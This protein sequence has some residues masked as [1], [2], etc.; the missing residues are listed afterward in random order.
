MPSSCSQPH[1]TLLV[2]VAGHEQRGQPLAA[3]AMRHS[4]GPIATVAAG[5]RSAGLGRQRHKRAE[6]NGAR[7]C[8]NLRHLATAGCIPQLAQAVSLR[9]G[10]GMAGR[11]H[12]GG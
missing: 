2:D 8:C 6:I 11:V 4:W 7:V 1:L 12:S 5:W 9:A 3:Q 10:G